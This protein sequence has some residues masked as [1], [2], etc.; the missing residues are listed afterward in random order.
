[1]QKCFV[2]SRS[3]PYDPSFAA[4]PAEGAGL[5]LS[6]ESAGHAFIV[7]VRTSKLT[8]PVLTDFFEA[9]RELVEQ[10]G[11]QLVLDLE[12]VSYIDSATIGCL[13]EIH[14]L[15][16]G[17]G[18]TVKLVALQRRVH[19]ML[20]MTGVVRFLEVYEGEAEALASLGPVEERIHQA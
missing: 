17:Q 5:D 8:Y 6:L 1:M 14:R 2:S 12:A 15:V 9:V 4:L 18:G 16:A 19:T 7:R 11:R 10:G 13:V 20:S 3:R